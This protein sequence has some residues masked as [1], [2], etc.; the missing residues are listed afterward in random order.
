MASTATILP[1]LFRRQ[2]ALPQDHGAWVFMLSPLAIGLFAGGWGDA[3]A[4]LVLAAMAAFLLRQPVTTLVKVYSHRRPRRDLPAAWFWA[5]FYAILAL[6]GV[7]GLAFAGHAYLVWLALPGIPVFLIHLRLVSRREERRQMGVE[8]VGSGVLALAAPA[9]YWVG[10]GEADPAGWWLFGLTWLQS[11]ASIVY[12]YLRLEQRELTTRPP[13]AV[14]L[15]MAN[16]A[17]LYTAFN[18]FATL[19][20]SLF[21]I[22]PPWIWL[23]YALQSAETLYGAVVQPAIGWKPTR[24]GVRQLIVSVLFTLLFILA[25]G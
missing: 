17:F 14:L 16:R 13:E 11:A 6:V 12:A 25:W 20:L 7:L 8:L 15:K 22:L 5:G 1:S 23:P 24:I 2:I 4:Y 3:S 10:L 21:K 19:I 9:A 18:L